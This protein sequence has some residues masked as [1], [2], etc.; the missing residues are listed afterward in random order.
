MRKNLPG[1]QERGHMRQGNRKVYQVLLEKEVHD[2][3]KDFGTIPKSF[4][5]QEFET[6]PEIGRSTNWMDILHTH[7]NFK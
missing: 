6:G 1:N 5:I 4:S 2:H 7:F 3:S